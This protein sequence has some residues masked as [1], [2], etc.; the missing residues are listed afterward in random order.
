MQEVRLEKQMED[1]K[2]WRG[3]D[4]D[5]AKNLFEANKLVWK[6]QREHMAILEVHEE[7]KVAN[8]VKDLDAKIKIEAA[9]AE[10]HQE[11]EAALAQELS[12][13]R[14]AVQAQQLKQNQA[15]IDL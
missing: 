4:H 5:T 9:A 15:L 1:I 11:S 6:A 2:S 12:E 8:L 3:S 14:V 10:K 7:G 13:L